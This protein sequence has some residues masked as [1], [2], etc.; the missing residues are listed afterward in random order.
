MATARTS[1]AELSELGRLAVPVHGLGDL[2]PLLERIG[3]ARFVL[4][5]EASHGTSEFY[6]WRAAITRRLIAERGFGLVA[7]EGDWPD[8]HELDGWVKDR[9]DAELDAE[10]VLARFER[11]PTWMWANAE[12][13]EFLTWLRGHNRAT[14]SAVGFYGLDVYSLWDSMDRILRYLQAELPDAVEAATRALHCFE[15]H[16]RDPQRY[17]SST[18]LVPQGC[19]REVAGLLAAVRAGVRPDGDEV[20]DLVQNTE[21]VAGAERYYRTMVRG[22]AASWNVRD[23]HMADTLDRLMAHHGPSSKVVVWEHNTHV[24]DARGT[25]MAAAGMVT[26]GQL[27]RERH[28]RD[29]V[30]LVGLSSHSGGVVAAPR[31][32]ARPREMAAPPAPPGTHEA[33]LHQVAGDDPLLVVVPQQQGAFLTGRRGHRAIGVVYDPARDHRNWVPTVLADRYDALLHIDRTSALQPL[34][35]LVAASHEEQE[36]YP[37]AV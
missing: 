11:W 2:D 3:D 18:R 6:R 12:V 4:I 31:W 37:W 21:V 26:V 28:D 14:G 10:A 32:G 7:V 16:D 30:V 20:L 22:D 5:G 17:A 8:C 29:G 13:A 35:P 23:V 1:G 19:E 33:L 36:T 27:V 25:P 34:T 9:H 15:P 24:G